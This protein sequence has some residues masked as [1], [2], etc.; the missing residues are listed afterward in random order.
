[1][2]LTFDLHT[3]TTFSHGKGSIEENVKAGITAGLSTIGISDHGPGHLTYGVKRGKIAVMREE[4]SRLRPLYPE[5][6]ILL[7]IEANIINFSGRTDLTD[8]EIN[9]LDYMNAGYHFGVLGEEPWVSLRIHS[10][11][12][13]RQITNSSSRKLKKLN[14]EL[15]IRALNENTI[16]VLTHS[17][18]KEDSDILEIAKTCATRGT[19]MEI[20][21]GHDFLSVEGIKIASKTDVKFVIQ[22]DAH[23]PD[24]VGSFKNGFERARAAGLDVARI[25][26]LEV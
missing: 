1:M 16:K 21:D 2:K 22:S 23:I 3:H 8:D 24:K 18:F 26:N 11:N 14:T 25:V 13:F 17:G 5:I 9:Q 10:G 6:E 7:G 20:S 19:Y 12:L 4:I 15:V